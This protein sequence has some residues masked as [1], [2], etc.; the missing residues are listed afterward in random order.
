MQTR[1]LPRSDE[2]EPKKLFLY[3]N[4]LYTKP[5]VPP[6][7]VSDPVPPIPCQ[8]SKAGEGELAVSD[9]S[10][11]GG[12]SAV[13]ARNTPV[14][15]SQ[16]DPFL[17]KMPKQETS[18]QE[19]AR[20]TKGILHPSK[21]PRRD[22]KYSEDHHTILNPPGH[23]IG[24]IQLTDIVKSGKS[25]ASGSGAVEHKEPYTPDLGSGGASAPVQ[26]WVRI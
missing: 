12:V 23:P 18:S 2:E 7:K 15:R 26:K 6:P 16:R 5:A 19:V 20:S 1:S 21:V 13:H 22:L 14:D 11:S 9:P 8:G 25:S 10:R 17:D 24:C 3:R 4:P